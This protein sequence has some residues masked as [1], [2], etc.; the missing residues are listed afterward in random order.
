[1]DFDVSNNLCGIVSDEL[2]SF[3]GSK[4]PIIVLYSLEV[5]PHFPFDASLPTAPFDPFTNLPVH[6]IVSRMERLACCADAIIV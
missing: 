4:D 2:N 1:L 6:C 5:F 3:L